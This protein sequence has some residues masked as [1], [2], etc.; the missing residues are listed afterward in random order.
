MSCPLPHV[1]ILLN[2]LRRPVFLLGEASRRVIHPPVACRL[3]VCLMPSCS[4]TR[5]A[6]LL[7]SLLVGLD[8]LAMGVGSVCDCGGR[9]DVMRRLAACFSV[10]LR[11][12]RLSPRFLDT[13]GGEGNGRCCLLLL[14]FYRL[15][16]SLTCGADG[17]G[18]LAC[19]YG[20][21][22]FPSCCMLCA[23]FVDR[24]RCGCRGCFA[25]I[26]C[27]CVV[28]GGRMSAI[29]VHRNS[30][31]CFSIPISAPLFTSSP[32]RRLIAAGGHFQS[33]HARCY[34]PLL[35]T[36]FAPFA[37]PWRTGQSVFYAYYFCGE[38]VKTAPMD[39]II[40]VNQSISLSRPAPRFSCR[41]NGAAIAC[42][43]VS[44]FRSFLYYSGAFRN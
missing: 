20:R 41:A 4:L 6:S 39:A 35:S 5:L 26:Y 44:H 36:R 28:G 19:S 30:L 33:F 21:R 3:L 2:L 8:G 10:R 34:W 40:S 11:P 27:H 43:A 29:A 14:D 7:A 17:S 24:V 38:L 9:A 12:V 1:L 18:L 32:S 25:M 42:S 31:A 13:S 15:P 22:S 23:D 37:Y 16:L